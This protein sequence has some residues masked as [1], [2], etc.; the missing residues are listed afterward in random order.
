MP[1][2]QKYDDDLVDATK[3]LKALAHPAR[4]AILRTLAQK[5]GKL[6]GEL[7]S[8]EQ[9]APATVQQHLRDLKK[10]G[11]IK[12]RIFGLNSS[13]SIDYEKLE[14]M[15]KQFALYLASLRKSS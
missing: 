8:I 1:V 15:E 14:S 13:Y 3:L 6:N 9:M 10:A 2:L 11:L 7:I 12:G 4:L 5:G